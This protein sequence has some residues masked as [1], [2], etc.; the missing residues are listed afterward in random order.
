MIFNV[1][2]TKARLPSVKDASNEII[3]IY[4]LKKMFIEC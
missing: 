3:N 1:V 4:F 2:D